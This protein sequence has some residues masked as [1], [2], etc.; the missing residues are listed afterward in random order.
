MT[1]ITTLFMMLLMVTFGFA[2]QEIIQ[3]FEEDGLGGP[4]GGASAALVPDPETGGTRGQVAE[5]TSDPGGQVFQGINIFFFSGI[6]VELTTDKSMEM[7]VY[8][9]EPITIAPKVVA[10]VDG[11]PDSTTSAS[12]SGSGWE[13]LSFTFDDGFD[14]TTTADGEYGAFVIYYNWDSNTN[15][16]GTPDDR[17]F[18]V[19]NISGISVEAPVTPVPDGPAPVPTAP[20]AETYSIYNDTNG[21]STVF[22]IAYDFGGGL[23]N[24][25][26]LDES[27]AE[28]IAYQFNFG[29]GGYGQGEGGPDDVS[30]YDFV[31]FDYWAEDNA[32]LTGFRFVLID[33]QSGAIEEF[34]YEIGTNEALVSGE[35]TKV[36]IPMSYF[37][38]L[39]F[40]DT[41][42]FQWKVDPFQQSV[43][44]AGT[45]YIDNIL[46]TQNSTLS[47]DSFSQAE[48]KAYP[49]PT[50]DVWNIRTSE[51]IQKVEVYNITGRLVKEVNVNASEASINANDLS[52]GVYL[53]KISN[54][55]DQTRTI[56]LIKE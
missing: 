54:E 43:D 38:N 53:A 30:A 13:T 9:L 17:V 36:E 39:G 27:A 20:D 15:G 44:N 37:T 42:L 29:A 7:D 26:D 31:S 52:S 16:F 21:Y 47:N 2:Q 12:H 22:P 3:D 24:Q 25:P 8:S 51:N 4:F 46:L 50:Q 19:D 40:D 49:N 35:W 1:K 32:T 56:K 5:L 48:F 34:N 18:Y 14:N 55:F 28:N 6:Q 41:V 23:V 33:N 45:V 11:A 10:G